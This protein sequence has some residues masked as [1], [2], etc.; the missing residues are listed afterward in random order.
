MDFLS[1]VAAHEAVDSIIL[2]GSRAV[3]DHDERSD[4]DVAVSAA[5]ITRL[6]WARIKEAAEAARSLYW[7]SLVH[8]ENNPPALQKRIRETGVELYVRA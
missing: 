5:S 1:R 8:L 2:F 7:I 3:G 6:D 4:I